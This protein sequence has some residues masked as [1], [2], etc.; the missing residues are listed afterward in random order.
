MMTGGITAEN[1]DLF[2]NKRV[3]SD[4]GLSNG[5]IKVS[6]SEDYRNFDEYIERLGLADE[7]NLLVLSS[8]H[9]YYYDAEEMVTLKTVINLKELN[10]IKDLKEFLHSMFHILPAGCNFIGCFVNNKKQSSFGLNKDQDF[11]Y[12]KKNSE[13]IE[14]GIESSYPFLNMV[15]KMIDSRTNKYLSEKSVS[16]IFREH[17]FKITDISEINSLSYFCAIRLRSADK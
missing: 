12:N 11:L 9:H 13:A 8:M 16:Q 14:N 4:I 10:Q 1:H 3:Q 7:S 17:G 6:A 15:Y 5:V 2:K